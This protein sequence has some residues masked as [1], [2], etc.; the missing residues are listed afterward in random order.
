MVAAEFDGAGHRDQA[1][2][3][4]DRRRHNVLREH[5]WLL[6]YFTDLDVYRHPDQMIARIETALRERGL[7][8]PARPDPP[9]R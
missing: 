2:L 6:L 1:Q 8:G 3:R 9:S 7:R 4:H 5:G